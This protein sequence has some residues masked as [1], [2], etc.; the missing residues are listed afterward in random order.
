MAK[1]DI[2]FWLFLPADIINREA[3]SFCYVKANMQDNTSHRR[4]GKYIPS[5]ALASFTIF[6]P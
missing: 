1:S 2:R 6:D 5:H 3:S 4:L